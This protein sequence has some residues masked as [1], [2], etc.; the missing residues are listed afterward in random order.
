MHVASNPYKW[1]AIEGVSNK[2]IQFIFVIILSRIIGPEGF[3]I[4]SFILV[5]TTIAQIFVEG[6]LAT[7]LIRKSKVTE[8][9]YN[10]AFCLN[11]IISIV[12]FLIVCFIAFFVEKSI[13][14]PEF[15]SYVSFVSITLIINA[16]GFVPRAKFTVELNFKPIA[17]ASIAGGILSGLIA[18]YLALKGYGI[19][20]LVLQLIINSCISTMILL[21][22]QKIKPKF[23][24]SA[25]TAKD[26]ISYSHKLI[27][28]GLLDA[29]FNN[30]YIL[31]VS[32]FYSLTSLGFFNQANRIATVPITTL[33]MV[34]QR[35]NM[36]TM[37]KVSAD[38]W[39]LN[40]AY[41]TSFISVSSIFIP[42]IFCMHLISYESIYILL[43]SEWVQ[44]SEFYKL[45]LVGMIFIPLSSVG[46]NIIKVV[47]DSAL[48][49]KIEIVKKI[50]GLAALSVSYK[51]GVDA[52][53]IA[54]SLTSFCSFFYI[55]FY[56]RKKLNID[57]RGL[58]F[59]LLKIII[60]ASF[61]YMGVMIVF[62]LFFLNVNVYVAI[63]VKTFSFI[64]L[65]L[66]FT[67]LFFMK[68]LGFVRNF[69]RAKI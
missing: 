16:F 33:T 6:G 22:F 58:H 31:V 57:W 62:N 26:L 2:A 40:E 55:Q 45:L 17:V 5:F 21:L 15:F 9:E 28:S 68:E 49:L 23:Q 65:S 42:I 56:M 27:W 63:L 30:V 24:Y 47:G 4:I 18:T 29:G 64:V 46:L 10:T 35:V 44:S 38:S 12:C 1:S 34:I 8:L 67:I 48:Y 54:I 41:R 69:F 11:V 39:Q 14:I 66:I 53:C 7:A 13:D 52:I 36:S 32:S 37:A 20:S 25:V 51:L 60:C 43:G 61:V 59:N 19:W 50:F 3:G